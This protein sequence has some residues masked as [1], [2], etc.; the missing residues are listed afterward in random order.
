M[1][2]SP[3]ELYETAYK[4]HY[5]ENNLKDAV[6][7]YKRLI[8]EFP[9]SNECG[10]AS[11]QLQK[12]KAH[13]VAENLSELTA[14]SGPSAKSPLLPVA[15]V[16]SVLA[17]L[18][19]GLV[20]STLSKKIDQET[21]RAALAMNTAGKIARGEYADALEMISLLKKMNVRDITPYEMAA[22]I[23]RRQNKFTDARKE[24]ETFF[25]MNPDLTPTPSETKYMNLKPKEVV[26][27]VTKTIAP[28]PKK[29]PPPVRKKR[30]TRRSR[31]RRVKKRTPPP[32]P[33]KTTKDKGLF[34]VDPDSISYF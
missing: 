22:D 11:I 12:I 29:V 5:T 4:L 16:L 28:K 25:Q 9:D 20:Y 10:Y 8:K 13:N 2:N 19:A 6:T 21:G 3:L 24:Y 17:L 33:G 32:Q 31:K 1:E 23:Y 15:V 18:A 14:S 30:P 7:Y 27:V 34:L 26:P